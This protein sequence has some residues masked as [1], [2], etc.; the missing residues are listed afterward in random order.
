MNLA[1]YFTKHHPPA[2]HVNVRAGFLT[3]IK[4]LADAQ[5]ARQTTKASE[6]IAT[7]QGCVRQASIRELAQ[8]VLA[9]RE[10]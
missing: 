9:K 2:H 4:D 8:R 1:D 3:K 10:I 5:A 6:K 7:L